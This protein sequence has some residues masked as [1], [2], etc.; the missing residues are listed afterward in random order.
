MT[1]MAY[2]PRRRRLAPALIVVALLLAAGWCGLWYFAA[3]V[4]ERTIAGWQAREAQAGRIH[5]CGAQSI[6]G[7]PL[8]FE[9]RCARAN[10]E[11]RSAVPPLAI[12]ATDLLISARLWQP[13][14]LRSDLVGPVT[15]SELGG[16]PEISAEWKRALSEVH[17]LPTSP[18]SVALRF[19]EP[20]VRRLS[21]ARETF[22][23][24][25]LD[26]DG[27]LVS[28][29]VRDNPVIGIVTKLVAGQATGLHP[30]AANATD[31]DITAV[32]R[33]LK[34]F[35]PKSWPQRFRELQQADG[36]IEISHARIQQGDIL[37]TAEG[38]LGLTAA[39]RLNGELRLTVAGLDKL[40]QVLGLEKMLAQET[41]SPQVQSALGALDRILP[42]L[43]NVARQNAA[44]AIIAG[45]GLMG[46][47]AE[48]EG[49]R[50]VRLPLRFVD[51]NVV[52]GRLSVASVPPLF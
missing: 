11:L 43:G 34:D 5:T 50:A 39:G 44:P 24:T 27:R 8:A 17:G 19:E 46:Q 21:G 40:L 52:L 14:V 49:R 1:D 23:A 45:I 29:S 37:A 25:R 13:T 18:E 28:G 26:I 30:A 6:S 36:R 32:L 51:G 38:A 9:M 35:G 48:L 33:G 7:F 22:K 31:A 3:G 15:V 42:G 41:A 4:A 16:A 47:P 2:A 12:A 20:S 10:I